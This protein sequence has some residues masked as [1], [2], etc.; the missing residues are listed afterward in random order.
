MAAPIDKAALELATPLGSVRVVGPDGP[1]P[2]SVMRHD[3]DEWK[4]DLKLLTCYYEIDVPL[5]GLA[6][7]ESYVVTMEGVEPVRCD[8][9]EHGQLN[10]VT[11]DGVTLGISAHN[12]SENCWQYPK[13]SAG[14]VSRDYNIL[15]DEPPSTSSPS[16]G[17]PRAAGTRTPWSTWPGNPPRATPRTTCSPSCWKPLGAVAPRGLF[18]P[19]IPA[20]A[21]LQGLHEPGGGLIHVVHLLG[22]RFLK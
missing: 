2:F 16:S 10:T 5:E 20:N 8:S 13:D 4:Y 14:S 19:L 11:Q 12:P 18:T 22:L 15:W 17:A 7:G 1:L 9:D 21:L 3:S 6:V